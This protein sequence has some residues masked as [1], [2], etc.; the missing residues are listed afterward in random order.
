M[1]E[2]QSSNS[3]IMVQVVSPA[4]NYKAFI[5]DKIPSPILTPSELD[6]ALIKITNALD[7]LNV[8]YGIVG[9][10]AISLYARHYSFPHR[11]T[12]NISIVIQP[13]TKT[14]VRE[15]CTKLTE[16]RFQQNF[17][18]WMVNG[19]RVPKV[20]IE[21]PGTYGSKKMAVSFT[22]LDHYTYPERR[23]YY[24]FNLDH[25][26]SRRLLWTLKKKR[27]WLMPSPWLLRQKIL[28][29]GDRIDAEK[30]RIDVVDINTLCDIM[31]AQDRRVQFTDRGEIKML[32]TFVRNVQRDPAALRYAIDCPEVLGPWWEVRW[33]KVVLFI[34]GILLLGLCI[35]HVSSIND[36][37]PEKPLRYEELWQE[38]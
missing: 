32:R 35:D 18:C 14:S 11:A 27:V 2:D 22:L 19:I 20:L 30:R 21:R 1:I 31:Q 29:W 9:S 28:A 26:G 24:D 25:L 17:V 13:T 37:K 23:L 6:E 15:I 36:W 4:P 5:M 34:F 3:P 38:S 8:R 16:K 7:S 10:A 33:R 12:S